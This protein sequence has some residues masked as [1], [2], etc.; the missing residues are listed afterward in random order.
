MVGF[1][2]IVSNVCNKMASSATPLKTWSDFQ[3]HGW[4]NF[5]EMDKTRLMWKCVENVWKTNYV[6]FMILQNLWPLG[7]EGYILN[8]YLLENSGFEQNYEDW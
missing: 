3:L 4:Y 6:K 1:I 8:A 7:N 2:D 5:L